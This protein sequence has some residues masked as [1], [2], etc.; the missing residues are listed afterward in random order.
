MNR[1]PLKKN[2]LQ[3]VDPVGLR[4]IGGRLKGSKLKYA[5]DLRVRPMKDRV[6][7]ATFNLIHPY[8]AGAYVLDLF[9]GTGALGLESLSRG[10]ASCVFT[11]QH[12]PTARVLRENIATLGLEER[13]Q[14]WVGDV[15]LTYRKTPELP[16]DRPWLVFCS[17]PY[18]FFNERTEAVR[19]LLA[20]L[21]SRSPEKS[22]FVVESDTTFDWAAFDALGPWEIR[23]YP[24]AVLGIHQVR[25]A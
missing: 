2:R 4:I 1:K 25:R 12:F 10:A 13:T 15:F 3:S 18:R 23:A 5:G 8:V 6:R 24:P 21:L 14:L 22:V 17:P 20:S 16:V 11:E 9:G 19:E 7:E